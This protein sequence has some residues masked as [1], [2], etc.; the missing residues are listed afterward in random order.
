MNHFLSALLVAAIAC[1]AATGCGN[2]QDQTHSGDRR[3]NADASKKP[4]GSLG[5]EQ[6]TEHFG[7]ALT[8]QP[9]DL[10]VGAATF[11]ATIRYHGEPTRAAKVTV[12][13]SMPEMD[14]GGPTITLKH[15]EQGVYSARA[16]LSMGGNWRALVKVEEEGHTGEATFDFTVMQ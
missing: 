3:A 5:V 14:M 8:A 16:D 2:H 9:A 10:K 13:L 4:G 1:L 11:K 12:I 15:E 7:I 6:K